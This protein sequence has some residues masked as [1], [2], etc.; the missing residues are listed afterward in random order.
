[1]RKCVWCLIAAFWGLGSF[2]ENVNAGVNDNVSANVNADVNVSVDAVDSADNTVSSPEQ[3]DGSTNKD[4]VRTFE[5]TDTTDSFIS[6]RDTAKSKNSAKVSVISVSDNRFDIA[7]AKI[8]GIDSQNEDIPEFKEYSEFIQTSWNRLC[9]ESLNHIPSWTEKY[10][11]EF[12]EKYDTLFYPFGGPD[13]SYA[14]SFFPNAK[15]YILVGLEALGNFD[16]IEKNLSNGQ[17]YN[18]VRTA[19]SHYLR[20]GYFITSEMQTQLSNATVKGGLN[21]VLLALKRLGFNILEVKNCSIDAGGN[22]SDP[23]PGN[24]NCIKIVCERDSAKKE[25]FY[26]RTNLS[27]E[28][29]KLNYL[30]NFVRKFK[31][32]TFVKSA[33][34]SLHDRNFTNIRSFILNETRCILQDDTG[35]PFNFFRR[36]WDVHIF[37]TYTKPTLPVFRAYKQNSLSE[38]Y[39]NH[40]AKPIPFPIGYGYVKRTPN[41]VFAVSLK[42]K[43]EEQL[44]KLK[45]QLKKKK[46][47]CSKKSSKKG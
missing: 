22:I 3:S 26:V 19:F 13:V 36:N 6:N 21:L 45:A 11:K 24:I 12:I 31:F 40:E 16:Q 18:S 30:T 38:Y 43:V 9:H 44:D 35:I 15:H 29:S 41:L 7:A 10:L 28:N 20:K 2:S 23:T 37:G 47:N 46:C 32:S 33:S 5:T 42:K 14:I 4:F 8:A 1:M 17:Y 39:L 27:N 34:Y 25:I